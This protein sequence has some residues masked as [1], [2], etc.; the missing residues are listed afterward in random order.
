MIDLGFAI[1]PRS[2]EELPEAVLGS[3]RLSRVDVERPPMIAAEPGDWVLGTLGTCHGAG[4]EG[5][6]DAGGIKRSAT[7]SGPGPDAPAEDEE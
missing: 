1:E 3:I 5:A 6:A 4:E 2:D 7:V